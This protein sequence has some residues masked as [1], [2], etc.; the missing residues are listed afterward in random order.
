MRWPKLENMLY[1]PNALLDILTIVCLCGGSGLV[2]GSLIAMSITSGILAFLLLSSKV[3]TA[4]FTLF[5]ALGVEVLVLVIAIAM[6][7]V[8]LRLGWRH[9]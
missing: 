5:K 8:G 2:V 6:W 7:Y 9:G 3:P 4:L 1:Q